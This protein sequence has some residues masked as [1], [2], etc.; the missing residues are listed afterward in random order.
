M[1]TTWLI[2]TFG[3]QL[4]LADLVAFSIVLLCIPVI[5]VIAVH[6]GWLED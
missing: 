4:Y 2:E 6:F 5:G 3:L 1:L